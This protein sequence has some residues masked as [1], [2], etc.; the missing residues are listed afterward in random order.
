M[1]SNKVFRRSRQSRMT[2][3][4]GTLIALTAGAVPVWAETPINTCADTDI[5]SPGT[6]V[7]NADLSCGINIRASNVSL[8]L[9][10]HKLTGSGGG[11][12]IGAISASI[13]HVGIEGPG[14]VQNFT[15]GGVLVSCDYC[16]VALVTF[17][18]NS[19]DGL[20]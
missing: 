8:K 17:A 20:V 6:Y 4:I 10:G 12:G 2:I 11:D 18:H 3:L 7:L 14:L 16:Q 15:D 13:N 1:K 9:N 5:S 19:S